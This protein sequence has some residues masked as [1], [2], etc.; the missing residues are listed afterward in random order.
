MTSD[1]WWNSQAVLG[2]LETPEDLSWVGGV[3]Y[4][5]KDWES[6]L[7]ACPRPVLHSTPNEW[8]VEREEVEG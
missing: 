1:L 5:E 2:S 8:H 7:E 3:P 6:G 4:E